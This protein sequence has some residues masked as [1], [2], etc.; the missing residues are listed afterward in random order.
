MRSDG[1]PALNVAIA[2][3]WTGQHNFTLAPKVGGVAVA[4]VNEIISQVLSSAGSIAVTT[5]A[6]HV[7][8]DLATTA[9][10]SGS[11][12]NANITVNKYGQL[13]SASNGAVFSL[14]VT[15]GTHTVNG[16]DEIYFSGASISSSASGI[17][18]VT[19]P[20]SVTDVISSASTISI[21]DPTGPTVYM[22]LATT[23]VTSGSYTNANLT[24]D[25]YGRL[26]AAS[27]GSGGGGGS[28][29]VTDGTTVVSSVDEIYF[30]GATVT[31][32]ASGI[33]IVTITGGGGG[34]SSLTGTANEIAVSSSVGAVTLSLSPN[35]TIPTPASGIALTV[36]GGASAYAA[37]FHGTGSAGTQKGV[38]IVGTTANAT[39]VLLNINNNSSNLLFLYADGHGVLGYN[40]TASTLTW[41]AAGNLTLNPPSSG[42]AFVVNGPAND[43]G[44]QVAGSSTSGQSYGLLVDAGTT[45]ADIAFRLS[46]HGASV[47]FMYLFG[48]GHGYL[49]PSASATGLYWTVNGN[50]GVYPPASGTALTVTG[51]AGNSP[52]LTVNTNAA[53]ISNNGLPALA[54]DSAGTY[55]G[56]ALSTGAN[57]FALGIGTNFT[58]GGTAVLSWGVSGVTIGAP[59][60]SFQGVGTIN[61]QGLFVNGVAVST[62]GSSNITPDTHPGSPTAWDDEFEYGTS[63]D[64]S[65]AR[66]AGA[67]AWTGVGANPTSLIETVT[68]GSLVYGINQTN[69]EVFWV[70]PVPASGAWTF[71]AKMQTNTPSNAAVGL[72]VFNSANNYQLWM[73]PYSGTLLVIAESYQGPNTSPTY[74]STLYNS[75][76][77]T[78]SNAPWSYYQ[79]SYNGSGTLSFG[80]SLTGLPGSFVVVVSQAVSTF[81]A[82][83]TGVG[84]LQA[85]GGASA[86]GCVDWFRRTA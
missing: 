19:I 20:S 42:T 71:T 28:L 80:W 27:N 24:V 3:S 52:A 39:D 23:A 44:L 18:I 40:G 56:T 72:G 70:Q 83:L 85:N 5:S 4:L 43:Y 14:E 9:V 45:S 7:Y 36:S 65:G 62:G 53:F 47:N 73:G 15:D 21:V 67:N 82:A 51:V 64:T 48:D 68:Q 10:T 58:S 61:A 77:T 8:V 46:N 29:E 79:I 6:S 30:S 60:S 2:P 1:A 13:T 31:S 59:T 34:V 22:D 16:V 75:A 78:F 74:F 76:P 11:Y 69:G 41:S 66:R 55:V 54:I 50:V 32:S 81:I 63:I 33:A 17:V 35:I 12:T 57:V 49:G 38:S 26:T 25:E 84:I 37:V 86:A